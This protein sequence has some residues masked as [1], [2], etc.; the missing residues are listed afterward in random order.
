MKYKMLEYERIDISEGIDLNKTV[1]SKECD[2][3]H[4]WYEPYLCN[5]CHDL[6][7]KAMSFN[8]VIIAYIKGTAYRIH[9]WC[10]SKD[11]VISEMNSSSL[12]EKKWCFIIFFIIYKKWVS[13]TPLDELIIKET[14]TWY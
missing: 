3:C 1:A 12:V 4:C 8:D 10:M 6:M 5:G 7:R 14:E 9:F 11:A 2:V 13:A